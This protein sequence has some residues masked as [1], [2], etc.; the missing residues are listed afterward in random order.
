MSLLRCVI[1]LPV[2]DIFD[3]LIPDDE[4]VFSVWVGK[5]VGRPVA[6]HVNSPRKRELPVV[7]KGHLRCIV[8]E[9]CCCCKGAGLELYARRR[10]KLAVLVQSGACTRLVLKP[11]MQP[12]RRLFQDMFVHY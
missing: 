5:W 3:Q 7:A 12:L 6:V 8:C 1:F 4:R 10:H 11:H 9:A 2:N